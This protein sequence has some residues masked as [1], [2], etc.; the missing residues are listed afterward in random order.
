[1]MYIGTSFGGCLRSILAGEVSEHQVLTIIAGTMCPSLSD[2]LSVAESYHTKGN[3]YA[4][5]MS[6]QYKNYEL[7]E[8]SI[9]NVLELVERLYTQ[10]K[11]HQPRLAYNYQGNPNFTPIQSLWLEVA[12]VYDGNN[13][14]VVDAYNKYKMLRDLIE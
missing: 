9:E 8:Y 4:S 1:M 7:K 11:I 2:L 12:P 6:K 5:R 3:P 13:H 14:A 10:G